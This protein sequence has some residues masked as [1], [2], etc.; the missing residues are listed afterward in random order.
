LYIGASGDQRFA[1]S[2]H[3]KVSFHSFLAIKLQLVRNDIQKL[4]DKKE[5]IAL[6]LILE[7]SCEH[8]DKEPFCSAKCWEMFECL[9]NWWLLKKGSAPWS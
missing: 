8:D 5:L 1:F 9:D 6:V 3:I 4:E 2:P 7:G